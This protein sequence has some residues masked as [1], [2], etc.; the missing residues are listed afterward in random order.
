MY[1]VYTI[2]SSIV[3]SIHTSIH[4]YI[5][6]YP[7]IHVYLSIRPFIHP[8]VFLINSYGAPFAQRA[9]YLPLH[10]SL[11]GPDGA[12]NYDYIVTNSID[13]LL[14]GSIC[15][16]VAH[17]LINVEPFWPIL[18]NVSKTLLYIHISIHLHI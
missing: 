2:H 5:Y 12:V 13:P 14:I 16:P 15:I 8:S 11:L 3:P 10:S 1:T 9:S 18:Q 17:T 7:Y 4:R 6:I